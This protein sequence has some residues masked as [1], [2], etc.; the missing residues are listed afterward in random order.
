M[1]YYVIRTVTTLTK[2][3][4]TKGEMIFYVEKVTDNILPLCH[5]TSIEKAKRFDCET[6]A[7]KYIELVLGNQPKYAV[8]KI[9]GSVPI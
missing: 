4:G 7:K 3:D 5:L 6:E 2:K 9:T 8:E 1:I